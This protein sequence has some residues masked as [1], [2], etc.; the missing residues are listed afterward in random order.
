MANPIHAMSCMPS[1]L[2]KIRFLRVTFISISPGFFRR[3]RRQNSRRATVFYSRQRLTR[4]DE[5]R[6]S[7]LERFQ[8]RSALSSFLTESSHLE[9]GTTDLYWLRVRQSWNRC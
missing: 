1:F 9:V 6:L 4:L 7:L 2:I 5:T 3:H 8:D